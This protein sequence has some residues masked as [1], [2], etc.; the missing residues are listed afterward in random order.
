MLQGHTVRRDGTAARNVALDTTVVLE[1]LYA[2]DAQEVRIVQIQQKLHQNVQQEPIARMGIMVVPAVL[3]GNIQQLEHLN[4]CH[5][6]LAMTAQTQLHQP[7]VRLES[8][9]LRDQTS[10]P[11]ACWDITAL[12]VVVTVPF[13]QL[14]QT[15]PPLLE[16]Q[17]IVHLVPTARNPTMDVHH[18]QRASILHP[19]DLL[20]A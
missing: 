6:N 15:V 12:K 4:V 5:V 11:H 7:Y 3:L 16:N 13:A 18:V 17:Q 19:Q 14:V 9:V 2:L 1:V 10:V 20:H 8:T